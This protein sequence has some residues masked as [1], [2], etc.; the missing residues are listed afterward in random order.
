MANFQHRHYE[1]LARIFNDELVKSSYPDVLSK[2]AYTMSYALKRDNPKFDEHRFLVA[3]GVV[4]KDG[5]TIGSAPLR[6]A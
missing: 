5:E 1:M 2:F 6:G 3:C 4:T